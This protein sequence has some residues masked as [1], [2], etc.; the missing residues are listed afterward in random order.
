MITH[1]A[2]NVSNKFV[3]GRAGFKPATNGLKVQV[4][5]TRV[6]FLFHHLSR[7][8]EVCPCSASLMDE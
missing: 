5:V 3:V 7:L 2:F 8:P 4:A 1:D 6:R